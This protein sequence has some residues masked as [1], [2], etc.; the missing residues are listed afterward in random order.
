LKAQKFINISR[1]MRPLTRQPLHAG[2]SAILFRE[3]ASEYVLQ[4]GTGIAPNFVGTFALTQR[5]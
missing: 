2:A 5:Q 1:P 4:L 3:F